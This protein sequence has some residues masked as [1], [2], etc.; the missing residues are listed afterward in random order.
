MSSPLTQYP[1]FFKYVTK[2]PPINPPAPQTSTFFTLLSSCK[3]YS[4]FFEAVQRPCC[5]S[6]LSS[7]LVRLIFSL[8]CHWHLCTIP[9]M[10][11]T[12]FIAFLI[13]LHHQPLR[14]ALCHIL[15]LYL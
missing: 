2:C 1:F 9:Y 3:N 6:I 8:L 11:K 14:A 5:S 15:N 7:S 10:P 13:P 12:S 4:S